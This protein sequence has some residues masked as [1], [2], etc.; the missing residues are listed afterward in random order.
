MLEL[1]LN[2]PKKLRKVT[3][4]LSSQDRLKIIALL[5][6]DNLNIHQLS[7]KLCL[8]VSTAASHVKVL[9]EANLIHTELRPASRGAMKVCTRNFDDIHIKLNEVIKI[10]HDKESYKIE[11]PIGQYTDF[12]VAP[13]CGMADQQQLIV[14]ED[15]PAHFYSPARS[16]AQ[17]IWTRKGF[18]EYKFPIIIKNE[19]KISNIQFSLEICSEAPN[20]DHNWPSD[21]TVWINGVDV[22]TWTSPGGDFGDRPG[23]LNPKYW[24]ETT[25]TQYGTLKTWKVTNEKT[26]IDEFYLSSVTIDDLNLLEKEYVSFRIGIKDDANHKGGMNILGKHF[27]DYSQDIKLEL[28]FY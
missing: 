28:E 13:T 27:G 20:H 7:E 2:H 6:K 16:T 12:E 10:K 17:L 15:E 23:K 19:A 9:E 11:M 21:I 8:P 18:L 1:S 3:H 25:S 26:M 22:G 14:P 5:N 24:A 4:A